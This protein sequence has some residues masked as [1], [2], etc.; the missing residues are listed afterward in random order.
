M[1]MVYA[2]GVRRSRPMKP[3]LAWYLEVNSVAYVVSQYD[4][5]KLEK[6]FRLDRIQEYGRREQHPMYHPS[7]A[8]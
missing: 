8:S 7:I 5:D 4:Q 6:T 2:R 1:M 3:R